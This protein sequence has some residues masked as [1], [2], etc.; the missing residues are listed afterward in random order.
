MVLLTDDTK[1]ARSMPT[2]A[3][4]L[5]AMQWLTNGAQRDD[6]LFLH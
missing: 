2:R 5:R 4:I 6:S 1:D 3:N